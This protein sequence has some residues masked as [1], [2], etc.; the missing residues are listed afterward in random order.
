MSD[1]EE[2]LQDQDDLLLKLIQ[3]Y[4]TITLKELEEQTGIKTWKIQK[5][6]QK[7]GWMRP[8]GTP[9]S[10]S[11][12]VRSNPAPSPTPI[13]SKSA[14]AAEPADPSLFESAA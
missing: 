8:R 11:K 1:V 13:A 6:L 14:S 9:A 7:L 12:W 10:G 2:T 4:P 3:E 5:S